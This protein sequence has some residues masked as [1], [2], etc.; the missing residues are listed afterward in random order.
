MEIGTRNNTEGEEKINVKLNPISII[1]ILN[2]GRIIVTVSV[3]RTLVA[4]QMNVDCLK[5]ISCCL[6]VLS[7]SKFIIKFFIVV[8]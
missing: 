3:P 6:K 5:L 4:N 8:V 7:N 1:S 2:S